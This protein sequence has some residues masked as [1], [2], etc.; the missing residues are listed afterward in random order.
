MLRKKK[1]EYK[2]LHRVLPA[3]SRK[4]FPH[5]GISRVNFMKMRDKNYA[6]IW[7]RDVNRGNS[8]FERLRKYHIARNRSSY[9]AKYLFNEDCGIDIQTRQYLCRDAKESSVLLCTRGEKREAWEAELWLGSQSV[10]DHRYELELKYRFP[11]VT[12]SSRLTV[13]AYS[14]KFYIRCNHCV[15]IAQRRLYFVLDVTEINLDWTIRRLGGT[16]RYHCR[17]IRFNESQKLRDSR[18]AS[19][20][21]LLALG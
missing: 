14:R 13:V 17:F 15:I 20:R 21:N 6:Y 11:Y 8:I 2:E 10:F 3:W 4:I 12:V 5:Y 1:T 19:S 7:V 18:S 16:N 9:E